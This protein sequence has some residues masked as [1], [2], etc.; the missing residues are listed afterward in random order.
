[1]VSVWLPS[2]DICLA[3]LSL[4]V[5]VLCALLCDVHCSQTLYILDL[6]NQARYATLAIRSASLLAV[7][8]C[9][10]IF[11]IGLGPVLPF[12]FPAKLRQQVIFTQHG[13]AQVSRVVVTTNNEG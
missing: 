12:R 3:S 1:M 5:H 8:C 13:L 6:L 7:Y 4:C 10:C 2:V 9:C 11:C